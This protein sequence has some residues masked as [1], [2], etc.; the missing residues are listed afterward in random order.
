MPIRT[1]NMQWLLIGNFPRLSLQAQSLFTASEPRIRSIAPPCTPPAA[2]PILTL[3]VRS[4]DNET[5]LQAGCFR[6]ETVATFAWEE[7]L[8]PPG[9]SDNSPADSFTPFTWNTERSPSEGIVQ[10][11]KQEPG[12]ETHHNSFS[13]YCCIGNSGMANSGVVQWC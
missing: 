6:P 13:L 8:F 3:P 2:F 7:W 9:N 12:N 5:I 10:R 11:N 4:K 1:R